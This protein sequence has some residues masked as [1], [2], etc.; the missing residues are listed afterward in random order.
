MNP[1]KKHFKVLVKPNS[2]KTELIG[3]DCNKEAWK[4][5]LKAKPE[6]NKANVQ[7]IKFLSKQLKKKVRI[8]SG[9]KSKLKTIELVE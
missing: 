1:D 8:K 9:L 4:I 6:N 5:A 7:L 2:N 3:Y